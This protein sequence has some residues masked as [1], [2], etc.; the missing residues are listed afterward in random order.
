[1]RLEDWYRMTERPEE[2]ELRRRLRRR[3]WL[4]A[5]AAVA[6]VPVLAAVVWL[7]I[8]MAGAATPEAEKGELG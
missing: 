5:L 1:M 2:R 4:D 7:M 3:K 6:A 8:L